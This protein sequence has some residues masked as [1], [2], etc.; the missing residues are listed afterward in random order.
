MTS[1]PLSTDRL[2]ATIEDSI[3]WIVI[4]NPERRNAISVEMWEEIPRIFER[5]DA[6][7][8]VRVIV[9]R[10]TG[11]K[12]FIAGLDLSQIEE[13]FSSKEAMTRHGELTVR[14]SERIA[15]SPKPTIAMIYGYCIGAGVQIAATCDLRIAADTA[16]VAITAAKLG[17]GYPL[18]SLWRLV[19]LVGSSYTKEIFFTGR[20]FTAAEAQAMGFVDRVLPMAELENF[21]RAYCKTIAKNAPLTIRAVKQTIAEF[22][23]V[24]SAVNRDFCEQLIGA[25]YASEDYIEGRRAFSEKRT[26]NFRGS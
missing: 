1:L 8:A 2:I 23:A 4:N 22:S 7:P 12:A 5:F 3:G 25:C 6:D 26:P 13:R 21:V 20:Q 15:Q 14:V 11:E 19:E 9:L 24:P 10:G 16:T 17:L 18:E